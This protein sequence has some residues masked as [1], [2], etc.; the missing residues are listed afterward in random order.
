M[1]GNRRRFLASAATLSAAAALAPSLWAAPPRRKTILLKSAWDT[2]NIGDI[3]HTPGTLRVFEQYLPDVDVIVWASRLNERIESM[4]KRRFPRVLLVQGSLGG[5]LTPRSDALARAF[6]AA[7]VVIHN[8]SMSN[9]TSLMRA[10]RKLG[11]PYGMF[12]QS[13]F[14]DFAAQHEDFVNLLSGAAFVYCRETLT[15]GTLR[16]AGVSSAVLDFNPDGC[17]GIDVRNDAA[18]EAFLKDRR[19]EPRKFITIQLRT[20]TQKHPGTDSF[21]NPANPTPEQQADDE[22]R[23]AIFRELVTAWVSQT[24]LKVLISPEVEKEIAHNKRLILDRLP[25]EIARHVVLRDEF[26]NADEAASVFARAHTVVCHEPHSCIIALAGGTPILHTYSAFHSPKY[27][28]FADIGLPEWLPSLDELPAR[29]IVDR[30]MA[31]HADYPAAQARVA[32]AMKFVHERFEQACAVIR[33]V[34]EG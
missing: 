21:L 4:L 30:L 3:G 15:L 33:R 12:G 17:F 9:D 18:A 6:E 2:V 5:D 14:P 34:I 29:E 22:R 26:W 13:Y 31:I 11:K 19:L 16:R 23:A 32:G 8:S 24:G 10:S 20:N 7:D 25:A 27:H 28:M 1:T